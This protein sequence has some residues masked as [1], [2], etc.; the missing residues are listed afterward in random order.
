MTPTLVSGARVRDAARER[1]LQAARDYH[2][3][4]RKASPNV[5]ALAADLLSAAVDFAEKERLA[6][7]KAVRD[8]E[9]AREAVERLGL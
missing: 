9:A 7:P 5:K 3:A 1:Y 6:Q 4:M 2:A 8:A